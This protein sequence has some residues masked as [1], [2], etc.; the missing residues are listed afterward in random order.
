ML[1]IKA[2]QM[3]LPSLFKIEQF[4]HSS[5]TT[6]SFVR[7]P[8]MES[9]PYLSRPVTLQSGEG[10]A[11]SKTSPLTRDH[12]TSCAFRPVSLPLR[13][14]PLSKISQ[15]IQFCG[16]FPRWWRPWP[17]SNSCRPENEFPPSH[18]TDEVRPS[19]R[20][21]LPPSVVTLFLTCLR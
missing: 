18:Q 6:L 4:L 9:S 11:S 12:A 8:M 14:L 21:S 13:S 17:P 3:I 5:A 20:P 1:P 16:Q 10:I 2:E 19:L 15:Q 7:C